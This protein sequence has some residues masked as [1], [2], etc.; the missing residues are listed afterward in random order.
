MSAG[1]RSRGAFASPGPFCGLYG[2]P[3]ADLQ[4]GLCCA[5][6]RRRSGTARPGRACTVNA[7]P[8]KTWAAGRRRPTSRTSMS[9]SGA[10]R[11]FSPTVEVQPNF[12]PPHFPYNRHAI[13]TAVGVLRLRQGRGA[14]D[15]KRA[16]FHHAL[17]LPMDPPR[18]ASARRLAELSTWP[19]WAHE[20]IAAC[21]C[22]A[23]PG[24]PCEIPAASRGLAHRVCSACS[25]GSAFGRGGWLEPR[26]WS[27]R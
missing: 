5:A 24:S 21:T 18:A 15:D 9:S 3:R 10:V 26:W 16:Q 20:E 8:R 17:P 22:A 1:S 12:I 13:L 7:R 2:G 4:G 14:E 19:V 6:G 11:S 27:S 23:K 25:A